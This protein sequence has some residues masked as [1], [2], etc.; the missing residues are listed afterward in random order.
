ME[1]ADLPAESL[2]TLQSRINALEDQIK[3]LAAEVTARLD[4]LTFYLEKMDARLTARETFPHL[5]EAYE[6]IPTRERSTRV[7]RAS[8]SL[9]T[10]ERVSVYD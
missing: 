5:P 3:D 6:N 8:V 9:A 7:V 4:R 10:R 2:G 1:S